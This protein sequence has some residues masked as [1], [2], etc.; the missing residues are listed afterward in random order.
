MPRGNCISRQQ[1]SQYLTGTRLPAPPLTYLWQLLGTSRML[2]GALPV[3]RQ[4]THLVWLSV[5]I[6]QSF[7]RSAS[8]AGLGSAACECPAGPRSVLQLPPQGP[9]VSLVTALT[10]EHFSSRAVLGKRSKTGLS[11]F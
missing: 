1:R 11:L 3:W 9:A 2:Q 10:S 4:T 8:G 7:L 6:L 5:S